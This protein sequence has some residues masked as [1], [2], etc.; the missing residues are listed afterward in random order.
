MKECKQHG[1]GLYL[2]VAL[3][4]TG[5]LPVLYV[6]GLG[7]TSWAVDRNLIRVATA[8]SLYGKL[9]SRIQ[10]RPYTRLARGLTWWAGLASSTGEPGW[11]YWEY[12]YY[13]RPPY[14]VFNP[15]WW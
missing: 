7:P 1:W 6:G 14:N 11:W 3:I 4:A 8:N 9:V 5:A 2:T 12:E 13:G 15:P 10:Q